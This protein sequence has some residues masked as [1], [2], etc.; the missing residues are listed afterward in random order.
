MK[1]MLNTAPHD[2]MG[3]LRRGEVSTPGY[4]ITVDH[5]VSIAKI[6]DGPV[7]AAAECSLAKYLTMLEQGDDR[8]VALPYWVISG[9]RH[10][11]VFC[12]A[13]APFTTLGDL[14]GRR[15]G[16]SN[17]FETG[18]TW[19]KSL[20]DDEGLSFDAFDWVSNATSV[21]PL[22]PELPD[23]VTAADTDSTLVEQLLDGRIDAL[24]STATPAEI[25]GEVPLLR[26]VVADYDTAERGYFRRTGI[27]PAFH[28]IVLDRELC[29][30]HP[31]LPSVVM[32]AL[33]ESRSQ[34]LAGA[35]SFTDIAPWAQSAVE[36]SLELPSPGIDSES[37]R[38]MLTAFATARVRQ[39]HGTTILTPEEMFPEFYRSIAQH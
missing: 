38:A 18:S 23:Y 7:P 27:Y 4:E 2:S 14:E 34:W 15:V 39:G 28:V 3:P 36:E 10:R 11:A 31:D 19:T 35:L 5:S 16:V 24:I 30:A 9:F 20:F 22:N 8:F 26:R 37:D 13:D 12:R 1:I 32:D 6:F 29:A 17:W 33:T 21:S 25:Y